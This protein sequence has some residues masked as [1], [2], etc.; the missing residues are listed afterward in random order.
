MK[1]I[2]DTREKNP[3]NFFFYPEIELE[4]RKLD[5][6][7]YLIEDKQIIFER[8]ATSGEIYLNLASKKNKDRFFREIEKLKKYKAYIICEFPE[9]YLYEFPNNSGIPEE[10]WQ[11]LKAN[12]K[13]IRKLINEIKDMGIEVIYCNSRDEAESYIVSL[14]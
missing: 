9:S 10:R 14:C 6:G 11:Y 7:D 12:P 13:Y 5:C 2:R 3:F 8:K 1:I 4:V